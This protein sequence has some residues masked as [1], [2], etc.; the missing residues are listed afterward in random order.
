MDFPPPYFPGEELPD[1]R[2]YDYYPMNMPFD[3]MR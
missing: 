3:H 2:A 1:D